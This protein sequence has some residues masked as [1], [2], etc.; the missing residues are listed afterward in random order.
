MRT[1]LD[2]PWFF[3]KVEDEARAIDLIIKQI[4]SELAPGDGY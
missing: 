2:Y 1:D 3:E 4:G